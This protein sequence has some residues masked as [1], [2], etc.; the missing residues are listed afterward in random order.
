MQCAPT[1][2]GA[3]DAHLAGKNEHRKLSLAMDLRPASFEVEAQPAPSLALLRLPSLWHFPGVNSESRRL[4]CDVAGRQCFMKKIFNPAKRKRILI[5]DD[6]HTLGNIYRDQLRH[7][8]EVEVAGNNRDA[9]QKIEHGA[10]DLVILDFSAP[11]TERAEMLRKIRSESETQKS[12][13][14]ILSNPFLG[15]LERAARDAGATRCVTKAECTGRDFLR[16]VHEVLA[17]DPVAEIPAVFV[18]NEAATSNS[19]TKPNAAFLRDASEALANLRVTHYAF[20]KAKDEDLRRVELCEMRRLV[21]FLA[22]VA[23][24]NGFDK[25]AQLASALE[26]LFIYLHTKPRNIKSSV[27]RTIA[28]AV[29]RLGSFLDDMSTPVKT[30]A[31][32]KVLVVDHEVIARKTIC[33]AMAK[34]GLAVV[35]LDNSTAAER[36]LEEDCFDLVF[37]DVEMPNLGGIELCAR[38][39]KMPTNRTTPIVMVT[40]HSDFEIRAQSILSGG[41]DFI[42]KPF[43]SVELAVKALTLLLKENRRTV[44]T[45]TLQD[46]SP[47]KRKEYETMHLTG[48]PELEIVGSFA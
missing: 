38:T 31:P 13:V 2:R 22:G 35:S 9:R 26:A 16:I 4:G 5:V 41:T 24:L 32:L 47:V 10:F 3:A 45:A 30:S 44:S 20:V 33:S 23:G 12:P 17:V 48:Y 42:A 36:L 37:L 28:Q 1:A 34:A 18:T 15:G 14:V 11:G 40:A 21:H 7:E 8:F 46:N 19:Q 29:D 39:R 27:V 25:A 43:V 6:D